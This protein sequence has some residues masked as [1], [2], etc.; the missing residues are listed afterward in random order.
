MNRAESACAAVMGDRMGAF[1]ES[2]CDAVWNGDLDTYRITLYRSDVIN[3]VASGDIEI[4]DVVYEFQLAIGEAPGLLAF[5]ENVGEYKPEEP[6]GLAFVPRRDVA[7]P[8]MAWRIRDAWAA[9]PASEANQMLIVLNAGMS[10]DAFFAPSIATRA[11]DRSRKDAA[12]AYFRRVSADV[13]P[14]SLVDRRRR[15]HLGG[16]R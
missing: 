11:A 8:E 6:E 5:G 3:C 16:G 1:L 10:Y 12:H 9:D 4:G 14:V 15:E 7:N 13:V 2:V